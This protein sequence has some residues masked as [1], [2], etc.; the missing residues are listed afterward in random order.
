[1]LSKYVIKYYNYSSWGVGWLA[2]KVKQIQLA[3]Y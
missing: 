2:N 3:Q 1:M